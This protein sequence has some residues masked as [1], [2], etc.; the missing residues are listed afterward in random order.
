[1]NAAQTVFRLISKLSFLPKVLQNIWYILYIV[2]HHILLARLEQW[3]GITGMALKWLRSEL[4]HRTFCISLGFISRIHSPLRHFYIV[5]MTSRPGCLKT[6]SILLRKRLGSWS[7][8]APLWHPPNPPN[9]SELLGTVCQTYYRVVKVDADLK[10]DGQIK[11]VVKSR[12]FQL[13]ELEKRNHFLQRQH[14]ETVIY[15]FVT[16][17][18]DY[19][20]ALYMGVSGSLLLVSNKSKVLAHFT[21]FSFTPLTVCPS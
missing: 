16:T 2:D 12:F 17:R 21:N 11:A 15:A 8:Q 14:F 20:N 4:S 10:F 3:V 5:W 1:M 13:R 19:C 18:L 6:F 9:W 7:L